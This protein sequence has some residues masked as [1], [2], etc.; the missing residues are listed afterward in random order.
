MGAYLI[1]VGDPKLKSVH[2]HTISY[3]FP[4]VRYQR[5]ATSARP[6]DEVVGP[7]FTLS[8]GI[9]KSTTMG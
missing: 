4:N 9:T 7:F 2:T 1:S 5:R 6:L 8:D 3:E